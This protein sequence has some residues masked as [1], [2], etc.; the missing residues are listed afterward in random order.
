[1]EVRQRWRFYLSEIVGTAVL[2]AVGL[3]IVIFMF[4][5]GS[6]AAVWIPNIKIRQSLTGFL[7]GATGGLT[8]MS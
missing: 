6:P 4:G 1:M 5:D 3:S 8:S 7:F 2:L